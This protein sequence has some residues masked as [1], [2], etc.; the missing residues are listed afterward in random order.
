[1]PRFAA[2]RFLGLASVRFALLDLGVGSRDEARASAKAL[3]RVCSG[4][5]AWP[6]VREQWGGKDTSFSE[7]GCVNATYN[8]TLV[9]GAGGLG[10]PSSRFRAPSRLGGQ[11]P[12]W[13]RG[14]ALLEASGN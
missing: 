13:T 6:V 11:T 2:T 9:F 12:T 8:R 4:R 7:N 1:V 3:R 10:L 5:N 14:F